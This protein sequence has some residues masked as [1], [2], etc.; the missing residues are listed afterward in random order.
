[1][2]HDGQKKP[3]VPPKPTDP[4]RL[5]AQSIAAKRGRQS[6]RGLLVAVLILLLLLGL[7]AWLAW[8][9]PEAPPLVV[10]AFDQVGTPDEPL[11][12][13]GCV[14]PEKAEDE[15]ANLKGYELFFND[16]MLGGRMGKP[17]A[18]PLSEKAGTP[19]SGEVAV[20]SQFPASKR[21]Y[22]FV[23][24]FP[25]DGQQPQAYDTARVFIWP[26]RARL[27]V[28]EARYALMKAGE[29]AF[30]QKKHFT[31]AAFPGAADAL[32]AAARKYHIVYLAAAPQRPEEYRK[33]RGWLQRLLPVGGSVFPDGPALGRD[34]YAAET[35]EAEARRQVLRALKAKFRRKIVGVVRRARDARVFREEGLTT[36][37]VGKAADVPAGVKRVKAWDELGEVLP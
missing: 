1:M 16:S 26:A 15:G 37:L 9:S 25:G 10:V 17:R 13:R 20:A 32:K 23:V 35:D 34:D 36:V 7:V 28:V 27:L 31:L 24:R 8:R 5:L 12:L 3:D 4:A 30:R 11:H 2:L 33:L 19:K 21:P 6:R 14:R 29:S 22:P 18:N